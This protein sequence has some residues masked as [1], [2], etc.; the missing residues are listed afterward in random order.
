MN[1]LNAMETSRS[2]LPAGTVQ[3]A[4]GEAILK[5]LLVSNYSAPHATEK[6]HKRSA[7]HAK[8]VMELDSLFEYMS[9][10]MRFMYAYPAAAQVGFM[11][12]TDTP[13]CT[14]TTRNSAR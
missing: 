9:S 7:A 13:T 8:N 12:K 5:I 3:D 4:R 6:E 2:S 10:M 1:V 14:A 11:R